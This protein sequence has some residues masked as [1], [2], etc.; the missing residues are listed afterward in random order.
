MVYQHF[1]RWIFLDL[2]DTLWDFSANSLDA[3]SLL[4]DTTPELGV[5]ACRG[6]FLDRYFHHNERLWNDYHY[7]RITSAFLKTERFRATLREFTDKD[8]FL[9]MS[10]ELNTRYLGY[11]ARGRK[12]VEGAF[13]LLEALRKFFLIGVLSNG[14]L[15]VQYQKIF[16]TGLDRYIQRL[17]VSDEIGVTKPD[18]RI[19]DYAIAETGANPA[20]VIMVGDNPDADISGALNAGWKAVYYNRKGR[21]L[22]AD[23]DNDRI[24]VCESLR[25]AAPLVRDLSRC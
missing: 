17:V 21:P 11:L 6:D 22:V 3:L 5:L 25:E 19:F 12:V 16:N 2:D 7:S 4:Y 10:G 8:D 24:R 13:E 18:R 14:F 9:E 23:A 1:S 20:D 15:D